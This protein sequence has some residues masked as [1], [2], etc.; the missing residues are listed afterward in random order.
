VKYST[1]TSL[2]VVEIFAR[3]LDDDVG[4]F[5]GLGS[6]KMLELEECGLMKLESG[7]FDGLGSL[8]RLNLG[9]NPDLMTLEVGAFDG[10]GSL[11]KL[12]LRECGFCC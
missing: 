2:I 3:V 8:V 10:L 4:T 11:K 7:L 5:D 1:I 9:V 6:L 12:Y